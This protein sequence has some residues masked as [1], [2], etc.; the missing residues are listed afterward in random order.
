LFTPKSSLEEAPCASEH[1]GDTQSG[2]V[3][4]GF[5]PQRQEYFSC[6]P[7]CNET[8][9]RQEP[10]ASQPKKKTGFNEIER[11]GDKW[12]QMATNGDSRASKTPMPPSSAI[13]VLF[14]ELL[15]AFEALDMGWQTRVE[16]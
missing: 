11:C 2:A 12:R 6:E 10:R 8:G 5:F 1:H 7:T 16:G 15:A 14:A 4:F 9:S 3:L 13:A